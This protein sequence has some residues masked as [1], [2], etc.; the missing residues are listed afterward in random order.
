M[1]YSGLYDITE[2]DPNSGQ[3]TNTQARF[4]ITFQ[5][6][7]GKYWA[8]KSYHSSKF[9]NEDSNDPLDAS[10]AIEQ[11]KDIPGGSEDMLRSLNKKK[12]LRSSKL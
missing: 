2:I 4:T 12:S 8:I 3:D 11:P 10:S 5:T 6:F 9:P 1:Q 7:D